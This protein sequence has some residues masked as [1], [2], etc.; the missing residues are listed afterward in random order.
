MLLRVS[1]VTDE[2]DELKRHINSLAADEQRAQLAHLTPEKLLAYAS[3]ELPADEQ[4][5]AQEHLVWCRQCTER[6]LALAPAGNAQTQDDATVS[7]SE[8]A[9]TWERTKAAIDLR[10]RRSPTG[11]DRFARTF[12]RP[13]ISH[14]IAASGLI[15]LV[16]VGAWNVMLQRENRRLSAAA[17]T[18]LRVPQASAGGTERGA[19]EN[20]IAELRQQVEALSEPRPN[21]LIADLYPA[22]VTRGIAASIPTL[23]V[24]AGA[25]L[26]TVILNTATDGDYA[27]YEIDLVAASGTRIWRVTQLQKTPFGNFTVALPLSRLMPGEYR[28]DLRGLTRGRATRLETYRMRIRRQ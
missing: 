11:S 7:D 4:I 1:G 24:P 20:E 17:P 10:T 5:R 25:T 16:A 8:I 12:G 2:Q 18:V 22:E 3:G 13:H 21:V 26:I 28:I 19:Y 6:L 15:A 23:D 27:E 9:S 14:V